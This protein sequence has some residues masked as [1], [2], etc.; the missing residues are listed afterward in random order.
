MVPVISIFNKANLIKN[1]DR[2]CGGRSPPRLCANL[3][4]GSC[5]LKLTFSCLTV[6]KVRAA[7]V[8]PLD[9]ARSSTAV[10]KKV[11][12]RYAM[13]FDGKNASG[14]YVYPAVCFR[15]VFT[16]RRARCF[17]STVITPAVITST[18]N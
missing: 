15:C 11:C 16:R 18:I 1:F 7:T 6:E 8:R 10:T 17:V 5:V 9:Y 12:V 13:A 14:V 4:G 2:W 3:M